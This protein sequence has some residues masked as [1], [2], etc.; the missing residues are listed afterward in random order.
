LKEKN[1]AQLEL[2]NCA[3]QVAHDIR[4][5]L[6]ALDMLSKYLPELPE[7]KRVLV[8]N[9]TQ[10]INDIANNLLETHRL[11]GKSKAAEI[12]EDMKPEL[13]SSLLDSLASEKRVQLTHKSIK[14]ILE[15]E[16]AAYSSFVNLEAREFKRVISNLINNASEAIHGTE[17]VIRLTL[18]KESNMLITKIIDNGKGIPEDLLLKIKKGITASSKKEGHGIGIP[19][20][21]QNIKS[22]G[23]N[24]DIQSKQG[25]GLS[26][27]FKESKQT[28]NKD[29]LKRFVHS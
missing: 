7:Q 10:R 28:L 6:A 16:N 18:E 24:Y 9:A 3:T 27:E 11:K 4:S 21:V 29:F 1:K 15:I 23:G 8:R 13:V 22:W 19:S 5:P 14:L 20:A 26:I 2:F 12:T 25:E 17:G